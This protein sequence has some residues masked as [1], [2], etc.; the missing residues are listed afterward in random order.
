EGAARSWSA[1]TKVSRNFTNGDYEALTE[2]IDELFT[3]VSD[4][5]SVVAAAITGKG[6]PTAADAPF[7]TMADNIGDIVLGSGNAQPGDVRAGRTFSNDDGPGKVGTVA[8][9]T[10]G[11]VVPTASDIIKTAGI[12]DTPIT[13]KG[14]V[15][16]AANV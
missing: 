2:N 14:V 15:V 3:S 12:Y 6:V 16:P 5:K 10:G 11:N 8:V 1:G 13:V 7:Q 4:G 9:Q